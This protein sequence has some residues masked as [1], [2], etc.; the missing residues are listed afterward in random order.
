VALHSASHDSDLFPNSAAYVQCWLGTL[1]DYR[2]LVFS[3]AGLA[4][5]AVDL[6]TEPGIP[7]PTAS[8]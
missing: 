7:C 4:Q 5:G 6:I 8:R 1:K 3:A 2:G